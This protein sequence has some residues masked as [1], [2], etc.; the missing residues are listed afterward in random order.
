MIKNTIHKDFK[1]QGRSFRSINAL[2]DY[3]EE[4]SGG[5]FQFLTQWFDH[6]GWIELKTSG[7]TGMPKLIKLHK[8]NMVHS[9][10]AT[11]SYFNLFEK[12]TAL[13]CMSPN[14][15]AGKM[16]LVRA[17]TLGWELD[18]VEPAQNPLNNLNTI[19]DF[20]AMV[21]MQLHNSLED[22]HKIRL[23]IVGGGVV[24][25][26]LQ[27]K[28]QSVKTEIFATYGMTETMSHI[29]VKRLN[30]LGGSKRESTASYEALPHVLFSH[31][32]RNCLVINAPKVIEKSIV[33]NDLVELTSN[34]TFKWLGRFDNIINSGGI[35]LSP[36]QIED[37]LGSILKQRF[38]VF[39]LPDSI[40]G[41]KL[42]LLIEDSDMLNPSVIFEEIKKTNFLSKYEI[43][44][45][46]YTLKKFIE[47][48]TGKINRSE[49][50]KLLKT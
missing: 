9:A 33:T 1:L 41:E 21:P 17:L 48:P 35:K 14:Y 43:P 20:S 23:L 45:E 32:D 29:A 19:Y 38:L 3:T 42:A 5:V 31:D 13:L 39:G 24:S 12:T 6:N 36:E 7:S 50:L 16:M 22:I 37:K 15:I 18:I 25:K 44:K 40:L 4:S 2:L 11:G 30:H 28:I 47:T 46:L 49:T 10:M 26:E 8:T 27:H 34:T